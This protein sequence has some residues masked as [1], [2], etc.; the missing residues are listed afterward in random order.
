MKTYLL[1]IMLCACAVPLGPVDS[2]DRRAA[3]KELCEYRYDCLGI[4]RDYNACEADVDE[5]GV[6]VVLACEPLGPCAD[7]AACLEQECGR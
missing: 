5:C 7:V 2:H 3:T 4:E 6:D 1:A